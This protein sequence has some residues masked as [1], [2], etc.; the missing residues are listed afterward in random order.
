[1]CRRRRVVG[2][3]VSV[4]LTSSALG[5]GCW[6][7][8][9]HRCVGRGCDCGGRE[10][11]CAGR[12]CAED[13]PSVR[14]GRGQPAPWHGRRRPASR[15]APTPPLRYGPAGAQAS[16]LAALGA[17]HD[18]APPRHTNGPPAPSHPRLLPPVSRPAVLSRAALRRLLR[19]HRPASPDTPQRPGLTS[20]GRGLRCRHRL[21]PGPGLAR[22]RPL[23]RAQAAPPPRLPPVSRAIL[24]GGAASAQ[25]AA[26]PSA[27]RRVRGRV[28]CQW[29]VA[30]HRAVAPPHA[31]GPQLGCGCVRRSVVRTL[32]AGVL[33]TSL[34]GN[35]PRSGHGS[36]ISTRVET[37]RPPRAVL[38]SG[39]SGVRVQSGRSHER[40]SPNSSA[41][42][43][44][45][46]H[47]CSWRRTHRTASLWP[48]SRLLDPRSVLMA[49][50][51]DA[52]W[53]RRQSLSPREYP[54][55]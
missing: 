43:L 25:A 9:S 32:T 44:G 42:I 50:S 33:P 15:S 24:P 29:T 53:E 10:D 49:A 37:R 46:A 47:P 31:V 19:Q 54:R 38:H 26:P 52:C 5:F 3:C 51:S 39:R 34:H 27:C 4:A 20:S 14:G 41:S 40:L 55:E 17:G 48:A 45:E 8:C 12:A 7:R 36:D 6:W 21:A 23:L 18:L 13:N 16:G 2:R 35:A 30:P 11:N 22:R 28:R 1:M